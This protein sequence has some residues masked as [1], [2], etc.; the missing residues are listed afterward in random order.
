MVR[1]KYLKLKEYFRHVESRELN[2]IHTQT[3]IAHTHWIDRI[4]NIHTKKIF[5][6]PTKMG[7]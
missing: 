5:L 4:V 1:F 2:F 3:Y 6:S 7:L